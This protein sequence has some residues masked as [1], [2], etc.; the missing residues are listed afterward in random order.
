MKKDFYLKLLQNLFFYFFVQGST[1]FL[2]LFIIRIYNKDIFGTYAMILNTVILIGGI[3]DL[4]M[5]SV[6]SRFIAEFKNNHEQRAKNIL[7]LSL[8][9]SAITSVII[10]LSFFLLNDYI[11]KFLFGNFNFK[12]EVLIS[13]LIILS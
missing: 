10:S 12:D 7:K 2:N 11:V 8:C 6:A 13:S 3:A 9:I 1:F 5:G 4:G